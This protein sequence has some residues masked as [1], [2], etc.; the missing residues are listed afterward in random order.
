MNIIV[1]FTDQQRWDTLGVNGSAQKLTPNLDRFARQGTFFREAVTPQPVCGPARSCLQTG[2]YATTTG[3]WRNGFGL[4]ETS[5]K[6]AEY[7]NAAGYRTGYIGKWHLSEG[8]GP[9]PVPEANRAGY[10]DWLG[11][12]CVELT[13]GPYTAK[14]WNEKD[15]AVSMPGYRSDAMVDAAIRYVH[16]RSQEP[17]QPFLLWLSLLEP[18]HQNTDDSYPA[19]HGHERDHIHATLPPDL[20]A[21]GGSAPKDWAG[22]CAMIQRIDAGLGRLCDALESSGMSEDTMLVF[23]SDHGCHFKTRN[24]EYKRS[25]HDVSLRVPMVFWGQGWNGGG[26]QTCAASLVDLA[27]T[28]LD[29]AGLEIPEAM[30][31]QSLLPA[32]CGQKSDLPE[33]SFSQFGDVGMA[34]GRCLR[35]SRW[36]YAVTATDEF[37]SQGTASEYHETHLYDLRTDPYEL[38]N[39][40]DL[41]S[42]RSICED[43]RQL[44]IE[45][46]QS[47]GEP[48]AE[49]RPPSRIRPAGQ[50]TVDYPG[51]GAP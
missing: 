45:R 40:I 10:R 5:P 36:K 38:V 24:S 41:E 13:S 34:P 16:E 19:P 33:V 17:D 20:Q 6:L 18:H 2:Q 1:F 48:S 22:Y 42:H 49:I 9:G 12:N 29:A 46:M 26:E 44:L 31:G 11:A 3:V 32:T 8:T 7:F 37:R 35:T 39:L 47:I 51:E 43:F 14:L 21:L 27:P 28:L 4:R 50:R 30:Q 25:P 15:E 23:I